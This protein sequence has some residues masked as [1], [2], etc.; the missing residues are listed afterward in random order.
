MAQM[1]TQRKI[2]FQ[3][4]TI[5]VE[6]DRDQY[7]RGTNPH[8]G[9]EWEQLMMYPYGEIEGTMGVDGDPVDCFVGPDNVAQFAHVVHVL[10]PRTGEMD[11][12]KVMLGFADAMEAKRVL[13]D[14]YDKDHDWFGGMDSMPMAEFKKKVFATKDSP[15]LIKAKGL[16]EIAGQGGFSIGE[17]VIVDGIRKPGS[18]IAVD[19]ER[20]TIRFQ[21]G[22]QL[23]RNRAFV[24]RYGTTIPG[25]WKDQQS[26]V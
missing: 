11:E 16:G 15:C 17:Q 3:G 8:S 4:M 24:R 20:V 5:R 12:D 10:N 23:S 6:T 1:A 7:R 25:M 22:L 26:S 2:R 9:E 21:D 13:L 18:V 19:G 14:H